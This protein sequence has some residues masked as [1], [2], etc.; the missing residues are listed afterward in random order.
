MRRSFSVAMACLFLL[1]GGPVFPLSAE[2]Q[3]IVEKNLFSRDRKYR[4]YRAEKKLSVREEE[5]KKNVILRGIFRRG[6]ETFV[7]LEIKPHLRKRWELD[8]KKRLFRVGEKLGPCVI[9][10]AEKGKV[11]LRECGEEIV[12]SFAD[13]PERKKPLPKAPTASLKPV[14]KESKSAASAPSKRP[15]GVKRFK[16]NPFKKLLEKRKQQP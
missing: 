13:S 2:Y 8:P 1:C 10:E 6:D 12:L 4:P 16:E 3:E 7:V 14:S 15:P 11:A 9:G 5:I